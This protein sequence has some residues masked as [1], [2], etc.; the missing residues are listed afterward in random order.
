MKATDGK[1]KVLIIDGH[2]RSGKTWSAVSLV[3]DLV[4]ELGLSEEEYWTSGADSLKVASDETTEL[5]TV[6]SNVEARM[7]ARAPLRL[8]FLDDLLGTTHI[9]PLGDLSEDRRRLHPYFGW[10]ADNRL[11]RAMSDDSILV[12]TG[13][14]LHITL[15]ELIFDIDMMMSQAPAKV[16][17][18]NSRRGLFR[19]SGKGDPFGTFDRELLDAVCRRNRSRH[20]FMKH[21]D[22]NLLVA[23]VPL[24]A[25]D[26]EQT[27]SGDQKILAARTLFG[28]DLECLA[29]ETGLLERRSETLGRPDWLQAILASLRA[30]YFVMVAPGLVFL[31][32]MAYEALG[33]DH[34]RSEKLI[35]SL[36]LSE[37]EGVFRSGRLPNEMYMLA[38]DAHLREYLDFAARTFVRL[39]GPARG[40]DL[41]P[42][43]GLRGFVERALHIGGRE[44]IE[45][46]LSI[47][48]FK[49][50]ADSHQKQS[51]DPF[52]HLELVQALPMVPDLKRR[53][54]LAAAIG[55]SLHNFSGVY[56][57]EL[58]AE[59]LQTWFVRYF[60]HYL[61]PCPRPEHVP[62]AVVIYSTFLQWVIK[63]C[64]KEQL[65][66]EAPDWA[67]GIIDLCEQVSE[68]MRMNLKMVLEDEIIWAVNENL[69]LSPSAVR[70][71]A[72]REGE[73]MRDLAGETKRDD[74]L[75]VNR[76]F[77]L[78]WHNEWMTR[79]PS[80]R[81][82][83][84]RAWMAL[85]GERLI[86]LVHDRPELIADNL[87]YHWAHFV[88][89][90]AVWMR[91]WCFSDN[92][93]EFE[94]KYSGIASGSEVPEHNEAFEKIALAVLATGDADSVKT[95]ILLA[96]TRASRLLRF[97]ELRR[98]IEKR[99]TVASPE[100]SAA[101]LHAVYELVRQGFFDTFAEEANEC[102]QLCL[103]LLNDLE[104]SADAAWSSYWVSLKTHTHY[105]VLPRRN[106]GWR[107]M[108]QALLREN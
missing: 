8:V 103:K 93:L 64:D 45:R 31:D 77:S 58:L 4:E 42:P 46:L 23:A 44:G 94:R 22:A 72:S 63:I 7:A 85:H 3:A 100:M 14:S 34:E 62:D 70:F 55:W 66:G 82:N 40:D 98:G 27:V 52:L 86:A 91:D 76:Y 51:D 6:L 25:F 71:I 69:S 18:H 20:T 97:P 80:N 17:V 15:A 78:S 54:G 32:P 11:L 59:A 65:E 88:T 37:S 102:R 104:T 105:D 108:R 39:A 41:V 56:G 24:L 67:A 49:A 12:I 101:L 5:F 73:L 48:E 89:Q 60:A 50:Y 106:E 33:V 43:L 1:K 9:R 16:T 10:D 75:D 83:G 92:P 2:P 68:P 29:E 79:T 28:E 47:E 21:G 99:L 19:T 96:G 81:S 57:R 38:V 107:D 26:L 90:R 74:V 13:R 87:R 36:Y 35:H 53:A 84:F 61:E 30:A 95:V